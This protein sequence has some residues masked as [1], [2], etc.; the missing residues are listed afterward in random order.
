MS[1][2][3]TGAAA[4]KKPPASADL[5]MDKVKPV[6]IIPS[7]LG[8]GMNLQGGQ[9]FGEFSDEEIDQVQGYN[10]YIKSFNKL[11]ADGT[12][13]KL[14]S[15]DDELIAEIPTGKK[16][17]W[18][19]ILHQHQ[20]YRLHQGAV[21]QVLQGLQK[22][23]PDAWTN[24]QKNVL[25]KSYGSPFADPKSMG[26]FELNGY[27]EYL[28]DSNLRKFVTKRNFVYLVIPGYTETSIVALAMFGSSSL[29]SFN[30]L[31]NT[32]RQNKIPIPFL[33]VN[34]YLQQDKNDD[35]KTYQRPCF[36]F[37]K[38]ADGKIRQSAANADDYRAKVLPLVKQ[39]QASH[40]HEMQVIENTSYAEAKTIDVEPA[41]GKTVGMSFAEEGDPEIP[42]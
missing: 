29:E 8:G 16:I 39:I 20:V 38:T 31:V 5:A 19:V 25:A 28:K 27:L 24:D 34:L 7:T 42:F 36:E 40:L 10:N 35:G 26:N 12:T 30:A 41:D 6:E 18:A 21:D 13:L 15:A 23:D 9:S 11:V 17:E 22:P 32:A 2:E 4:Q 37:S 3:K 14:I 1:N 33:R